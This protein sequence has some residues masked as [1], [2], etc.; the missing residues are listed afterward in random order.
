[1]IRMFYTFEFDALS[2]DMSAQGFLRLFDLCICSSQ[3]PLSQ[4][5]CNFAMTIRLQYI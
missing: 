1:M 2:T 4:L 5:P 3:Q